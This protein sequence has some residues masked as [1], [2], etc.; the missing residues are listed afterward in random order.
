MGSL[1]G[2]PRLLVCDF[3]A[4]FTFC[5][6]LSRV[7]YL[8]DQILPDAL[9]HVTVGDHDL[10]L[11]AFQ[12]DAS[13]QK[14]LKI[15]EKLK[16]AEL[17][18]PI[19]LLNFSP[20]SPE[21][22]NHQKSPGAANAYL[23]APRSENVILDM[24]DR[25]VGSPVPSSLKGRLQFLAQDEEQKEYM[26]KHKDRIGELEQ[27]V[28]ELEEAKFDSLDK[29]LE[30]Q[31]SLFKPKL[32]ALMKGK[33][34]QHQT[35]TEQLKFALSEM[36]A[37]LLDR[38]SKLKKFEEGSEEKHADDKALQALREFYQAKLKTL[39]TEKKDLEKLVKKSSS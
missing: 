30:A 26:Q 36:E 28:R 38:E 17:S 1:E 9:K 13:M 4:Q 35:E 25:L 24:L 6:V 15:V 37:K 20:P 12:T 5:D 27:K 23:A 31:R 8:V 29:A 39:E 34:L 18:T 7:G 2:V 3:E 10:Y 22:L 32:D 33:E 14:A 11:F 21:F 16:T 19:F